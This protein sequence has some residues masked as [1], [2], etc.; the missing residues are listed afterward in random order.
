MTAA[1]S[2]EQVVTT[3]EKMANG[4]PADMLRRV[5]GAHRGARALALAGLGIVLGLAGCGG[6]AAISPQA[7]TISTTNSHT[8]STAARIRTNFAS[9]DA[10]LPGLRRLETRACAQL[11]DRLVE[12]PKLNSSVGFRGFLDREISDLARFNATIYSLSAPPAN[13]ASYRHF[14]Y[15]N[16]GALDLFRRLEPYLAGASRNKARAQQL[17]ERAAVAD[18]DARTY[19]RRLRLSACATGQLHHG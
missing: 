6:S 14:V 2:R 7:S 19:G 4:R 12:L 5:I 13:A 1:V 16:E 11:V 15:A 17:M 18:R 8:S 9:R 3:R 10:S